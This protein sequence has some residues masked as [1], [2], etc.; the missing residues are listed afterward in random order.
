MEDVVSRYHRYVEIGVRDS[1]SFG[2]LEIDNIYS[3]KTR[4]YFREVLSSYSNGNYRSAVV[5]LYSVCICDLFLS[6]KS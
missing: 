6:Y 3:S 1:M 2:I 4:E 5:M